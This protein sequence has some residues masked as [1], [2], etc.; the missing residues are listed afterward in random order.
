LVFCFQLIFPL[1]EERVRRGHCTSGTLA[2]L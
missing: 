1:R 2:A